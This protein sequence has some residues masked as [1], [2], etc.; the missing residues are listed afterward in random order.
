MFNEEFDFDF[1]P[2]EQ[3][4][5]PPPA[6]AAFQCSWNTYFLVVT[7]MTGPDGFRTMVRPVMFPVL[8]NTVPPPEEAQAVNC[9]EGLMTELLEFPRVGDYHVVASF[10]IVLEGT[11]CPVAVQHMVRHFSVRPVLI[12][13]LGEIL[14]GYRRIARHPMYGSP[15]LEQYLTSSTIPALTHGFVAPL[16]LRRMSPEIPKLL[17]FEYPLD[18][19]CYNSYIINHHIQQYYH[20]LL[21]G[22]LPAIRAGIDLD[23]NRAFFRALE[24]LE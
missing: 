6:G 9:S 24:G 2:L 16:F 23:D 18:C 14:E 21:D 15:E 4:N 5:A 8:A 22:P 3:D 10:L 17:I 11:I 20:R 1:Q 19:V 7:V 12:G 13:R